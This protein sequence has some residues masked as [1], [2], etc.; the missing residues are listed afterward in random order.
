MRSNSDGYARQLFG[1]KSF[2]VI[3]YVLIIQITFLKDRFR[4]TEQLN[5]VIESSQLQGV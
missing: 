4:A 3:L 2:Y 5:R 1:R